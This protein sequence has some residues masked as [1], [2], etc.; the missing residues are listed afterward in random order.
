MESERRVWFVRVAEDRA[1]L[2]ID[3]PFGVKDYKRVWTEHE[4]AAMVG[5]AEDTWHFPDNAV[6]IAGENK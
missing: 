1:Y 4:D 2:L 5:F 6:L 3:T